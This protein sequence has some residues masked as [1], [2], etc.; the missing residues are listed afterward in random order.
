VDDAASHDPIPSSSAVT[1]VPVPEAPSPS[2]SLPSPGRLLPS[3]LWLATAKS[4]P[5]MVMIAESSASSPTVK[6]AV[7]L[8]RR[9]PPIEIA[10][11]SPISNVPVPT[12]GLLPVPILTPPATV[13][14]PPVIEKVP[15]YE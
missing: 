14:V 3:V 1:V 2:V 10:V 7:G 13:P 5:V 4:V 8:R 15:S 11:P 6:T 12:G 9:S